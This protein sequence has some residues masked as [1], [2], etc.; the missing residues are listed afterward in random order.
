MPR[1]RVGEILVADGAITEAQLG[2]A[3]RQQE[4]NRKMP[5]G[6]M[7]VS[8][9]LV[10]S[11]SVMQTLAKK[12]GVPFVELREFAI[13]MKAVKRVGESIA[14]RLQIMPL[15][16][17]DGR[18][19]V[20]IENPMQ[21]KTLEE[22]RCDVKSDVEAVMATAVDIAWAINKHYGDRHPDE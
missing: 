5:L 7:L 16:I 3:L 4:K 9:G 8:A 1:V 17:Q 19:V 22:L 6:E 13:D 18:M 14:R 10:S 15:Y 11:E 12:L 2:E 21:W 20:A